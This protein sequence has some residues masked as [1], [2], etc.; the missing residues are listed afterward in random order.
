MLVSTSLLLLC[1]TK[2]V[3]DLL[4][5]GAPSQHVSWEEGII[6]LTYPQYMS[7]QLHVHI[8]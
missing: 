2:H 3:L 1:S 7:G 5:F 4:K 8:D 6:T